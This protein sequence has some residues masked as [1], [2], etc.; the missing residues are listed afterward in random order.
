MSK[1]GWVFVCAMG[2]LLAGCC[3]GP[4]EET[5]PAE[6]A[7]APKPAAPAPTEDP[8][9]EFARVASKA[10]PQHDHNMGETFSLGVFSH[11]IISRSFHSSLI[12]Q[13]TRLVAPP[14]ASY[15]VIRYEVINQGKETATVRDDD[16]IEL[17]DSEGRIYRPDEE[18]MAVLA[19]KGEAWLIGLGA[20]HPGVR[21]E[22]S[23]AFQM[24]ENARP[25]LLIVRGSRVWL[26]TAQTE[27]ATPGSLMANGIVLP[28]L[29]VRRFDR[30]REFMAPE[31]SANATDETMKGWAVAANEA[32]TS[33][34]NRQ[35]GIGSDPENTVAGELVSTKLKY[36]PR[37]RWSKS[38]GGVDITIR[39][40]GGRY[41]FVDIRIEPPRR[42]RARP[43]EDPS[44]QI[45][46]NPFD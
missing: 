20:L 2:A 45:K 23:L 21:R 37:G 22:A 35:L 18:A 12:N 4:P 25:R 36:L 27:L 41:Y 29:E 38:D 32:K 3:G 26:E 14:G 30:I 46:A 10:L 33:Q 11:K 6:G 15:L 42:G 19:M 24:P 7:T 16:T 39:H 43:T 40:R 17:H 28:L 5:A 9:A 44:P 1:E 31:D 13:Y 8:V 34:G